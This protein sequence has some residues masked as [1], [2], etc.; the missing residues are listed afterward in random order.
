MVK[1]KVSCA[2]AEKEIKPKR[3]KEL[4][5]IIIRARGSDRSFAAYARDA[6]V[7]SASLT[8]IIKGDYTPKPS[9]LKKLVS[10]RAAPRGGVTYE[11]LMEACGYGSELKGDDIIDEDELQSF[12]QPNRPIVDSG[13]LREYKLYEKEAVSQVYTSLVERGMLFKKVDIPEFINIRADLVVE[14]IDQPITEWRFDMK[15]CAS[16]ARNAIMVA[17]NM[18]T[19]TLLRCRPDRNTKLSLVINDKNVFEAIR[20]YE[21]GIAYRGEFSVI[22]FEREKERLS[23]EVYLSNYYEEDRSREIYIV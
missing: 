22:L 7:S 17:D 4:E 23:E 18:L 1:S 15:Y 10:G 2:E 11:E 20:K 13:R 12:L 21:H 16:S 19:Q 14:M 3:N 8:R 9:V 6:G 5:D